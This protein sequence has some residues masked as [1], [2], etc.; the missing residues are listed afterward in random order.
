MTTLDPASYR[1]LCDPAVLR[2]TV[3][4]YR[5]PEPA[6]ELEE[7]VLTA[8]SRAHGRLVL[9]EGVWGKDGDLERGVRFLR[10]LSPLCSN[11]LTCPLDEMKEKK[12][13]KALWWS[14]IVAPLS[15]FLEVEPGSEIWRWFL[16]SWVEDNAER[17]ELLREHQ[18]ASIENLQTL[19]RETFVD[20][21]LRCNSGHH[22]VGF[23]DEGCQALV[24]P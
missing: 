17:R 19:V 24:A 18:R 1:L 20:Y 14:T 13:R 12:L 22:L 2:K 11:W 6:T 5:L 16:E 9:Q 23:F 3:E 21:R 8:F 4:E 10:N 15:F 7:H